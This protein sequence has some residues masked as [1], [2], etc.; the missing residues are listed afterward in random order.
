MTSKILI[1]D[2]INK[3]SLD[4]L[5]EKYRQGYHLDKLQIEVPINVCQKA[6]QSGWA[7]CAEL[8][9]MCEGT[10]CQGECSDVA[11]A[12]CGCVATCSG[13]LP[14]QTPIQQ[15]SSS[16]SPTSVPSTISP[17]NPPTY[18]QCNNDQ[19]N[20]PLLGCQNKYIATITGIFGL[21]VFYLLIKK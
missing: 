17:T 21:S 5:I 13:V 6:G 9:G 10:N 19:F 8:G 2:D 15:P 4:N 3:M 16:V 1:I 7:A 18:T 14:S 11:I 20:I 12:E